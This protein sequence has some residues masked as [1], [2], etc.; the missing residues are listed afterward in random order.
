[1]IKLWSL[2]KIIH[3]SGS[4]WILLKI[5]LIKIKENHCKFPSI[6]TEWFII[7][8]MIWVPS[9][10]HPDENWCHCWGATGS[11]INQYQPLLSMIHDDE[12][13]YCWDESGYCWSCSSPSEWSSSEA[14]SLSLII[15]YWSLSVMFSFSITDTFCWQHEWFSSTSIFQPGV[16]LNTHSRCIPSSCTHSQ[17]QTCWFRRSHYNY[18]Y[19]WN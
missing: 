13:G 8:D 5:H 1:M 9:A 16:P 19:R 4:L 17:V 14:L 12:S 2:T 18:I 6:T 3:Y 10:G 11:S 7:S 15:L